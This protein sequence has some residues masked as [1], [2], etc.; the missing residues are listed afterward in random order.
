VILTGS[1][2]TTMYT[3]GQRFNGHPFCKNCGVQVHQHLIGPP[4][5]QLANMSEARQQMVIQ[6]LQIQPI[7]SRVLH[8][9]PWDDIKVERSDEGTEG[10]VLEDVLTSAS[11]VPSGQSS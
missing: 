5:D 2:N 3:F 10:Y 4:A 6:K 1:D 8:G 7:N 11:E 9:V